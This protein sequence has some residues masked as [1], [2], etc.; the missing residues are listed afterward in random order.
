MIKSIKNKKFIFCLVVLGVLVT[1]ST[2]L[3]LQVNWPDSPLGTSLNG[4]SELP[5][6]PQLIQYLYE[7]GI[8]L[9]G[10]A[11][12]IA[13]LIAG[14]QF[15]T[16]AGNPTQMS[17]AR[18]R[19]QSAAVGLVL[20]LGSW[21]ILYTINPDL[22]TFEPLVMPSPSL[23]GN[24]EEGDEDGR[25]GDDYC[26][27][28][29]GCDYECKNNV[30][31]ID[32]ESLFKVEDCSSV[33]V[34][35]P[36]GT[37]TISKTGQSIDSWDGGELINMEAGTNFQIEASPYRCMGTLVLAEK[38]GFFGCSGDKR[39]LALQPGVVTYSDQGEKRCESEEGEKEPVNFSVDID[40]KCM[41]LEKL[42]K[43]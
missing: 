28:H 34:K 40:V 33:I 19:I 37:A 10:L 31:A 11:A 39:T 1:S 27:Y 16:S 36:D 17:E 14:F 38:K 41:S 21:L 9:G 8:A 7:W 22:T 6:L 5:Q 23:L 43:M 29:F 13:L 15:L 24:C 18:G 32:L 42:D 25:T 30:C 26:E 20:L 2:A 3:A 12:F 4:D 35:A